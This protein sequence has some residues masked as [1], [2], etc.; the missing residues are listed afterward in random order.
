MVGK[1]VVAVIVRMGYLCIPQFAYLR[2]PTNCSC[3]PSSRPG[4]CSRPELCQPRHDQ[5]HLE[6]LLGGGSAAPTSLADRRAPRD[7]PRSEHSSHGSNPQVILGALRRLVEVEP[8]PP[9]VLHR[10]G[11][12]VEVGRF[13]N[14]GVG[15]ELV[16]L[17]DV[18][19]LVG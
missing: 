13:R 19:V 7:T 16:A 4:G 6:V 17:D 18:F 8:V 12:P 9:E 2:T 1:S 15:A 14:V 11:E 10:L 5:R 3:R